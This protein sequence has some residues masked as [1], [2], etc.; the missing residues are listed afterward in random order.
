MSGASLC[1]VLRASLLAV[2]D[3]GRVER[4]AD[5]LVAVPREVLD[6]AAADE[7]DRVLLQV[8]PLTRDVGADLDPVREPDAR[9]LPQRRVRLLRGHR[10]DARADAAALRSALERRRLR[11]LALGGAAFADEL[12]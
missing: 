12:V 4:G 9:D 1:P 5:H 10:R 3:A 6:A 11:L 8:V 2:A 7:H